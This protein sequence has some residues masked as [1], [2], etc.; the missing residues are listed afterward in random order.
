M[1][2][3][4]SDAF[5]AAPWVH[6]HVDAVGLRRLCCI[7]ESAPRD[8]S[9]VSH[10][11]FHDSEYMKA[12]RRQ[13][14]SGVLPA[15]CR[16]CAVPTKHE[17]YRLT[18]NRRFQ[19]HLDDIRETTRED[20]STS[21]PIVSLDYR[22][23]ACNL[24]C[25][26]C[27]PWSSS[28]WLNYGIRHEQQRR[29]GDDFTEIKTLIS[30]SP[31]KREFLD[32][33]RNNP[34][35]DI[36]FA[37]GEPLTSPEHHRVLDYLIESRRS[38]TIHLGYNTNL[39]LNQSHIEKWVSRL[40]HFKSAYIAC[41]IDG[42]REISEYIR[43]GLD[44][45]RFESN[46]RT[47]VDAQR[48]Y[49]QLTVALDPTMTSL[50]LLDLKEFSQ[51]AL[52]YALP[53]TTK[54]MVGNER[55][56]GYLRCEFLPQSIR[57]RVINE[58]R[59][60]YTSLSDASQALLSSLKNNLELAERVASFPLG[61]VQLS[62]QQSMRADEAFQPAIRF[63][64]FLER[65]KDVYAWWKSVTEPAIPL[66]HRHTSRRGLPQIIASALRKTRRA[67]RR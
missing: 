20:G 1:D 10:A 16:N 57:A 27:G 33:V 23:H 51:F 14:M 22:A 3:T 5:C 30:L 41:S 11:E 43:A 48:Q 56:A 32:I 36:Y 26:T 46:L 64:Q 44:F 12:I 67:F 58:W 62:A 8:L 2:W 9:S 59:R 65:N 15:D 45:D 13:M 54:L 28:A 29:T 63:D 21:S 50:F 61:Q 39:S 49:P 18:F 66:V 19:H 34:I 35:E 25:R 40:R 4:Q 37:G 53:V 60:Y 42:T 47:L 55:E 17:V 31:Y 24:K 7:A 52:T 38:S 6:S